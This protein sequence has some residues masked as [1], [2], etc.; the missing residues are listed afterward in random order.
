M[1]GT[2]NICVC[3]NIYIYRHIAKL[4]TASAK[5]QKINMYQKL[6]FQYQIQSIDISISPSDRAD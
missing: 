2:S 6:F 3:M 5:C 1:Y 4:L